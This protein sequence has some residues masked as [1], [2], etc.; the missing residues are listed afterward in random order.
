MAY[1]SKSNNRRSRIATSALF[2]V[3][4]ALVLVLPALASGG[5]VPTGSMAT[6]RSRHFA[7][8]LD[9][10]RV[11]VAAGYT[12]AADDTAELYD[13]ATGSWSATGT[14]NFAHYL[15]TLTKLK[16]G[17]V[18]VAGGQ[19]NGTSAEIYDPASGAWTNTGSLNQGRRSHA[20]TLLADGRVLVVGGWNGATSIASAE[21]YDPT[22]GA[23]SLT[24]SLIED[25]FDHTATLLA[26]GRVLVT[27]GIRSPYTSLPIASAEIYDPAA[28]TWSTT[29]S[30][31][32][33]HA[34]HTATLLD[35]GQVFIAGGC[36][37]FGSC[38]GSFRPYGFE[39]YDPAVGA[40]SRPA[41]NAPQAPDDHAVAKLNDGKVFVGGLIG[42][43]RYNFIYDPNT[44]YFIGVS[45][46]E[47]RRRSATA[48]ALN[49]GQVLFAGGHELSLS[50]PYASAELYVPEAT[51]PPVSLHVGDLDSF[52]SFDGRKQW[53]AIVTITVLDNKSIPVINVLVSG[54]WSNSTSGTS[55][56]NT[57]GSGKCE[58]YSSSTGKNSVSFT[59]TNV[60]HYTLTYDATAN[61]DPDVDS[62][63]TTIIVSKP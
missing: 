51:S 5:W 24:A 13:P 2:A 47:V 56:C 42:G 39:L 31:A 12:D 35:N 46:N 17:R 36:I 29:N 23:W 55:T 63:G 48:T 40:W 30:M 7:T 62:N 54:N 14:M 50:A 34:R 10:G 11:L 9:D 60:S 53:S 6:G 43:S 16:D 27:G 58:V 38:G 1:H 44:D 20:A 59:V 4:L 32:G 21:I 19:A 61:Q 28:G 57:N 22:S 3:L 26:D 41:N 33:T 45:P 15:G 52:S 49:N 18:L 8:R 37:V 25:R